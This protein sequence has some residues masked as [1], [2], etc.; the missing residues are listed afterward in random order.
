M[1]KRPNQGEDGAVPNLRPIDSQNHEP[2]AEWRGPDLSRSL[3]G[4]GGISGLLARTDMGQWIAGSS[5]ATA[6]YHLDANGNVTC[7]MYPNGTLAAKYLYDPFGNMLSQYG[8]MASA[9]RYRFSSKE[10]DAASGLYYY[11]YRFYD[12]NLQ[13]WPNRDPLEE[14][15]GINLYEFVGNN[16]V[17]YVDQYGLLG[18]WGSPGGS[19]G[20]FGP[21]GVNGTGGGSGNIEGGPGAGWGGALGNGLGWAAGH[22]GDT[23]YGPNSPYSQQMSQSTVGQH[24]TQ[25]F[26]N[27]NQGKQCKDWQGV[28]HFAGSFG[29]SGLFGNLSN[30]TAEF[31][32]SARGDVSILSVNCN[33][34]SGTVTADF[35]LTNTTSLTSFLYGLWPNS[36]NVTTPGAP[37]SNWTQT[38]DWDETFSCKCC[39]N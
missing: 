36:W 39:S 22:S 5:F 14:R 34:G 8:S 20:S 1:A 30:G 33:G 17:S 9:N 38:Y 26:L 28:S 29:L 31:V 12:P 16:P 23:Q 15:G 25:N 18:F 6:F 27:K 19:Y 32:G 35:K 13:R 37:F 10:W 4:A 7:L 3:Q 2:C 24:L 11:L 21:G